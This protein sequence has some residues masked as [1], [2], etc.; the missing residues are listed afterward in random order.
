MGILYEYVCD[1]EGKQ[2]L[3]KNGN[4]ITRIVGAIYDRPKDFVLNTKKRRDQEKKR[5]EELEAE[6]KKKGVT[7]KRKDAKKDNTQTIQE[8]TT[9]TIEFEPVSTSKLLFNDAGMP[10]TM[11]NGY[12]SEDMRELYDDETPENE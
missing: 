10:I 12:S 2:V 7:N 1:S 5:L 3:D 4:P 6:K 8:K 11:Q 9:Q